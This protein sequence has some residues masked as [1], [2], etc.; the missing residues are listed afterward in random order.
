MTKNKNHLSNGHH[1][2]LITVLILYSTLVVVDARKLVFNKLECVDH[3]NDVCGDL[4]CSVGKK[5]KTL[6]LGCTLKR[7]TS[8]MKVS[9]FVSL[10]RVKK[11]INNFNS[12]ML[13]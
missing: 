7:P 13:K 12:G 8:E 3:N 5:Q 1:L 6:S 9:R 2:F 10:L 11:Y 4:A